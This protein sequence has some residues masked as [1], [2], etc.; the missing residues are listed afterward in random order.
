MDAM[1]IGQVYMVVSLRASGI[2][3]SLF[4]LDKE[5]LD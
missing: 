2:I 1:T 3:L 4:F 5:Y